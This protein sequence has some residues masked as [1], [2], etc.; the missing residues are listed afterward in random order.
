MA[1][2]RDVEAFHER[3]TGYE[4]GWRGDL[5]HRIADRAADIAIGCAPAPRWVLDLGCGTGY[6]LRQLAARCP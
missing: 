5:H 2:D 4:S 6:L 3:A 1:R